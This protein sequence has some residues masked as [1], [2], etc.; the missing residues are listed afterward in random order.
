MKAE[1]TK[2]NIIIHTIALIQDGNGD[3]ESITI[4]K[5]VDRAGA[6]VGL[7]NHYFGTKDE[8]IEVCVQRVIY[9]VVHSFSIKQWEQINP[10]EITKLTAK[11]VANFLM[12][13]IQISKLSIISDLKNPDAKNNTIGTVMGFAYCLSGG[14]VTEKH[15][16][17]AFLLTSMIQEAFLHR[18]LLIDAVGVDF[19]NK[20]ARDQYIELMVDGLIG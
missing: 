16:Q 9:D 14:E 20:N 13:N 12:E 1:K 19:Y 11:A 5:I 3:I 15:K 18:D 4:R 10:I 8:L 7:I 2:E 17:Q 6:S